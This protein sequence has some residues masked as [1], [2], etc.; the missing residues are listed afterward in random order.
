V[1]SLRWFILQSPFSYSSFRS[2][3]SL[4]VGFPNF[5]YSSTVNSSCRGALDDGLCDGSGGRKDV[6]DFC[7]S[8]MY[9]LTIRIAIR[10][11]SVSGSFTIISSKRG[12]LGVSKPW[13]DTEVMGLNWMIIL[14]PRVCIATILTFR[15]IIRVTIVLNTLN[16]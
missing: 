13:S 1:W 14:L 10:S 4:T 2:R 16:S 11:S 3:Y 15:S 6:M 12:I 8:F 5:S 7:S 9:A